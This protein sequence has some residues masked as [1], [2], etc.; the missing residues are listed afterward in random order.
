MDGFDSPLNSNLKLVYSYVNP[1]DVKPYWVLAQRYVLADHMFQTQSSDSFSAHQVSHPR[2]RADRSVYDLREGQPG[3][4]AERSPVGVRRAAWNHDVDPRH[5]GRRTL[6]R[7]PFP[8]PLLRDAA[9]SARRQGRLVEVLHQV[10]GHR[11]DLERLR[12]HRVV[13]NGPEWKTNIS[14]PESNVITDAANDQ[15][16]GV[17]WVV[18]DGVNSDHPGYSS[19]TGPSWIAQVVNAIGQSKEWSSTAIVIVWDDWGGFYDPVAPPQLDYA[20]LGF[21]VPALIISP[22]ARLND[23]WQTRLRLAHAVRVRQHSSV[24]RRQLGF[25]K[26]GH[27]R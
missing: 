6:R 12:R 20:G 26:A 7:R 2:K 1:S 11:R 17:A 9:Q 16:P 23:E 8:V 15:L 24:R 25:G 10:L 27:D 14:S 13:R 3:R 19:D 21:R 5:Q 22:Y 18:P 4:R